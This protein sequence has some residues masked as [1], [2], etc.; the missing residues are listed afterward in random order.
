VRFAAQRRRAPCRAVGPLWGDR[1]R[2]LTATPPHAWAPD[3][4]RASYHRVNEREAE[5]EDPQTNQTE[6]A[7]HS[8][9]SRA[10]R[11]RRLPAPGRHSAPQ[12]RVGGS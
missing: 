7:R 10:A 3:D 8:P 4:R 2:R 5:T 11:K 9:A 6:E 12:L 1:A